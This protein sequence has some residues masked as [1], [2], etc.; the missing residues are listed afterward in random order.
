MDRIKCWSECPQGPAIQYGGF[1]RNVTKQL[2][3][4]RFS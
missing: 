1:D 3:T 4:L 2:K